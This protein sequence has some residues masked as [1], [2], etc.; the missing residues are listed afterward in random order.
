MDVGEEEIKSIPHKR[1]SY[2]DI[3]DFLA[4]CILSTAQDVTSV[5]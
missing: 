5:G 1:T 3:E 2:T 4:A